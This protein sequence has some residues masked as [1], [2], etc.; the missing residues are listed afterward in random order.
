MDNLKKF[1][2]TNIAITIILLFGVGLIYNKFKSSMDNI[3]KNNDLNLVKQYLLGDNQITIE[4]LGKIKKPIIWIHI[5]YNYNSRNWCNF[6]SR[7][8]YELNMPYI[9]LT[10]QT[11]INNCGADFHVCLIDDYTFNKIL[12]DYNIDLTRVSNPVKQHLRNVALMKLLHMYGGILIENSFICFKSIKP[13]Y[14]KIIQTDKP[15][16]GEFVNNVNNNDLEVFAP[17]IKLIGCK[18]ECPI[19]YNFIEYLEQLNNSDFTFQ[20]DFN[21]NIGKWLKNAIQNNQ[22]ELIQGRLIGTIINDNPLTIDKILTNNNFNLD[23]DAYMI[24]IPRDEILKRTR[25]NWIVKLS[26]EEVLN[27]NTNLSKFL[28]QASDKSINL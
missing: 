16:V 9:Y 26:P 6:G 15:N 3:E 27:S 12:P 17:S 22:I 20:Q 18:R 13:L 7:S 21:G 11:I 24:Y 28:L 23:V 25:Y 14:D 5:E 4:D 2:L 1:D 8:N 10:I 19:I